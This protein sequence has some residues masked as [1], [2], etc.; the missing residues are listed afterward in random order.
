MRG[1]LAALCAAVAGTFF[2]PLTAA[3]HIEISSGA[4]TA[5]T[6]QKVVF[7]VGHGCSGADTYSVK[8]DI[9][10]GVTSVRALPNSRFGKVELTKDA[11]L[12]VTSVTWSKNDA[13]EI[14]QVSD[15]FYYELTL[16]FKVP[17]AP[18]TTLYFPAHQTCKDANGADTVVDWVATTPSAS[19]D[20]NAPEPAPAL[21]ILPARQAGW[22]KFTVPVAIADLSEVFADAAIVWKDNAAYSSNAATVEQIGQTSGVTKLTSLAAGD[23]VWV[24]Y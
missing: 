22:N 11:A 12:N 10:A 3:A 8:I 19:D 16:R 18:F 14:A 7:G 20:P 4:A 24:K 6:S 1:T 21:L 2:S 15:D 5:G 13:S 17:S 23:V 9:P